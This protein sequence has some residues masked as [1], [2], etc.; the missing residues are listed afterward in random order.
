MA[1][2]LVTYWKRQFLASSM[3]EWATDELL[4]LIR[5]Y[6]L[7]VHVRLPAVLPDMAGARRGE[8]EGL[9]CAVRELMVTHF[10]PEK[11]LMFLCILKRAMNSMIASTSTS[12]HKFN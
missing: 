4:I 11:L 12:T 10:F 3:P 9:R 8:L 7:R 5:Q 1:P 6:S 2:V